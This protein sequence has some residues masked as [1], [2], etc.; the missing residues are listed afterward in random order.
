VGL[1]LLACISQIVRAQDFI[2]VYHLLF[3]MYRK[4]NGTPGVLEEVRNARTDARA[5][6]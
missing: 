6:F 1:F 3:F 5:V 4:V 2:D